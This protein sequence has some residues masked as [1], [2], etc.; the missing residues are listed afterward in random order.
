MSAAIEP[1]RVAFRRIA[2]SGF[3]NLADAELIP[4][5]GL[6]LITGDN[7][8]GKTSLLEAFY[9]VATSRSFRTEKLV[10]LVQQGRERLG[11]R[12]E[13]EEGARTREQ[14]A[15]IV[16][17][18][19]RVAIDGKR[20]KRLVDYALRTPVVAF[21]PGDLELVSGAAS[22]RRR[23]L[24]RVALFVD[25]HGYDARGA[26]EQAVKERQRVLEE[27]GERAPDL[28]AYEPLIAEHGARFQAARTAAAQALIEHL[29]PAFAR[30]GPD[31]LALTA[32]YLPG[33]S[34]DPE[35]FRR[36]LRERRGR[37]RQRLAPTFGPQRDELE[38]GVGEHP[39]R[40]HASQ[41]QQR[42]VT[43]ALKLAELAC[44]T[45]ARGVLPVLLLD[46]VSSELDPHRSLAVHE[47]LRTSGGQV[48]VTTPRPELLA[49]FAG[50]AE[51]VEWTVENGRVFAP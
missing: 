6:T 14:R 8:Q 45:A 3:R 11:A 34:T 7:G 13:I 12:A 36:E 19:R 46:D 48:F 23:L 21:H 2:V 39:A 30:I 17:G 37:D 26:Y 42:L 20:P 22:V 41:G 31:G 25:P 10:T 40:F 33:G 32:R 15:E 49:A 43:L 47:L 28:E 16:R 4:G 35:V 38:L 9:F 44:I 1:R 24:D 51:R 18:T 50:T 27:R 5:P 29:V